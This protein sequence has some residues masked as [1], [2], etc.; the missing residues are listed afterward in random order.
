MTARAA[1]RI[2]GRG[3]TLRK[4]GGSSAKTPRSTDGIGMS[5]PGITR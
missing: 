5:T 2:Y 1:T 3:T 4:S